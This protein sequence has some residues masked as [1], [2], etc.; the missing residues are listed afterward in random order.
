MARFLKNEKFP[1]K[2]AKVVG[3]SITDTGQAVF[4]TGGAVTLPVGGDSDRP[5]SPTIGMTRINSDSNVLEYYNGTVWKSL[6]GTTG[7]IAYA[8]IT[9]DTF[10]TTDGGTLYGP[11]T[12]TPTNENNIIVYMD[13]VIQE[14]GYN[15]TLADSLGGT[16][17][18]LNFIKFDS[19]GTQ[20]GKRLVV[21]QGFDTI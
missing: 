5:A 13:N 18:T 14:P 1:R 19:P 6:S 15:Y 3:F 9:K 8:S 12:T 16:T 2:P 7:V 10:V 4:P 11:I 17:G 20:T 21:V